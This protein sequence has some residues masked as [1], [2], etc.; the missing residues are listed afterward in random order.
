[1]KLFPFTK[2]TSDEHS[3]SIVESNFAFIRM[4][5]PMNVAFWFRDTF[6]CR[7]LARDFQ[8]DQ[9]VLGILDEEPSLDNGS[10][11]F[12]AITYSNHLLN[13]D[14]ITSMTQSTGLTRG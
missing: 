7:F 1:M 2:D 11:R 9:F 4:G 6:V 3:Q 5:D 10:V 13:S 12:I 14:D 8:L